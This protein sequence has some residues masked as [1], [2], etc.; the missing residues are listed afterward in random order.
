MKT[1]IFESLFQIVNFFNDPRHD[2]TLL[3]KAGI[4]DDKNL[5]PIIV[6]VGVSQT[7]S[8]GDLANQLGKNHSS[9]SRQIDKFEKQGLLVSSYNDNDRR[10][11]QVA[12]TEKG[13]EILQLIERTRYELLD[14]IF[15]QITEDELKGI[16][17]SLNLLA[18]TLTRADKN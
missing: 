7:I 4:K 1:D 17:N 3:K 15:S 16:A 6:R 8:I 9:T 5:L 14:D 2:T 11:R 12:L 10:I 18:T 13:T